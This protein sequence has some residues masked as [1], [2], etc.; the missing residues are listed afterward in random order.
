MEN[1]DSH[2]VLPEN[3]SAASPET[4]APETP[5]WKAP[6]PETPFAKIPS[7]Q[8]ALVALQKFFL[9]KTVMIA[10]GSI[11]LAVLLLFTGIRYVLPMVRYSMAEGALKAGNYLKASQR[12]EALGA[13]KDAPEK[14]VLAEKAYHYVTA[15]EAFDAGDFSA[16]HDEFLL[17]KDYEDASQMAR[18]SVLA[19]YYRDGQAAVAAKDYPKAITLFT[20]AGTYQDAP[21]RKKEAYNLNGEKLLSEKNYTEAAAFF[22]EAGNQAK[23]LECGKLLTKNGSYEDA[24]PILESLMESNSEAEQYFN[25]ASGMHAMAQK[26]YEDA[27]KYL[28]KAGTLLNAAEKKTES[29]FLLAEHCLHEGYL[30]KAKALYESLPDDYELGG[31][32]AAGRIAILNKNKAFLNLVGSWWA[33]KGQY[34]VRADSTTS[35]YYYYWYQDLA[36][37]TVTVR[38]PYNDNGTFSIVGTATYPCYQNFSQY[39]SK[40]KTDMESHSFRKDG[41]T[42]V[43]RSFGSKTCSIQF[44]GKQFTLA[45]KYVNKSSNVYWHYTYTSNMTYG[46]HTQMSEDIL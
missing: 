3:S 14:A 28:D 8:T 9:R 24:L 10:T 46:R 22:A 11:L 35:S 16:A 40:L 38:C 15:Q 42:S 20:K 37:G 7:V 21:E 30:N 34:K 33:T 27:S 39:A 5:A 44:N 31:I 32:N 19:G 29:L 25:Y 4:P 36:L 23:R 45:Y 13:Y 26:H 41:L 18:T 12:Y 2:A 1:N 17:A 6:S 43:P